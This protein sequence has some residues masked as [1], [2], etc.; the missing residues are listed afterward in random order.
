MNP[1]TASTRVS[2]PQASLHT[3]DNSWFSVVAIAVALGVIALAIVALWAQIAPRPATSVEKFLPLPNGASFV[4]R[5]TKPDNSVIYRAR[6]VQRLPANQLGQTIPLP[7][8]SA[9]FRAVNVDILQPDLVGA[10]RALSAIDSAILRDVEYDAQGNVLTQTKTLAILGAER[11]DVFGVI[12]LL[13]ANDV[14]IEPPLPALDLRTPTQN[15]TGTLNT[16]IPYTFSLEQQPLAQVNT[17]LGELRDCVQTRT[18][19]DFLEIK[20]ASNT[21]YCAGVGEVLDEATSNLPNENR[22]IEIVAAS[23]G[24]FLKGSAPFPGIGGITVQPTHIFDTPIETTL[25][26]TLRYKEP[27]TSNGVTTQLVP[28]DTLVL[29]GTASGALVALNRIAGIERWRFQTGNAIYTAPI[30]AEGIVYFGSA[31]KK[32]YAVRLAD[33][34]FVW[35]FRT[36]DIVSAAPTFADGTLYVASEDRRLYA[37]DADTGILR[38]TFATGSPIVTAPLVSNSVVYVGNASGKLFALD[39]L[40]GNLRWAFVGE[41]FISAPL[42]L[43]K[44]TLFVATGDGNLNALQISDG[45]SKWTAN[46]RLNIVGQP[47]VRN[48][49]VYLTLVNEIFALD[50]ANGAVIWRYASSQRDLRGTPILL[51]EQLWQLTTQDLIRLD[52]Q[53]G[54]LAEQYATTDALP[55]AG[56]SSDG[57]ALYAGFF[58]GNVIAWE[59][60]GE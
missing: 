32:V 59:G 58:D 43:E 47:L 22:R 44:D 18:T 3:R 36:N 56:L 21:T 33:G 17:A 12:D 27:A 24:D 26:E 45:E 60:R 41:R 54:T 6:N 30:V 1:S 4:Y 9:F 53:T 35:A 2:S 10:L 31:D 25:T 51:S 23:V 50:A 5:I 7:M 39:A 40:T 16:E 14:A 46:L 42:T 38:W 19:L 34:A 49:R 55:N 37:L 13:A 20:N 28:A 11:I 52:A 48:G 15:F 29:Y 8:T 57:R